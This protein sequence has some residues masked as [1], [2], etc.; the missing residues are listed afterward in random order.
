MEIRMRTSIFFKKLELTIHMHM[1]GHHA[2]MLIFYFS[3]TPHLH[4]Q[5]QHQHMCHMHAWR[6]LDIPHALSSLFVCDI[7]CF[8]QKSACKLI[9][10]MSQ[11]HVLAEALTQLSLDRHISK[12]FLHFPFFF[13]ACWSAHATRHH[14]CL[15]WPLTPTPTLTVTLHIG[16][17][18]MMP[19]CHG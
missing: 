8:F 18:P 10:L 14:T 3:V 19:Q 2:S 17:L 11:M 4:S 7:K 9:F 13:F 1:C 6:H 16:V 15:W 12:I 5:H